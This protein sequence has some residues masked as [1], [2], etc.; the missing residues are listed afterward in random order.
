MT[1]NILEEMMLMGVIIIKD[2]MFECTKRGSECDPK[3]CEYFDP[4]TELDSNYYEKYGFDFLS[5][6]YPECL[7]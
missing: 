3:I 6:N 4:C 5:K 2:D 1:L 7:I